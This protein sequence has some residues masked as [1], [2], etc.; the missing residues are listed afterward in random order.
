MM[1]VTFGILYTIGNILSLM[2]T[3]FLVGPRRQCKNM[4][5]RK[6]IVASL[7]F[8]GALIG[9]LA[10]AIST[11]SIMATLLMILIQFCALAWYT[12]SY[13]PYARD[14]VRNA[15]LGCFRRGGG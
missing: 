13:I 14:M 11:G 2:S 15:L 5:H 12:L 1:P 7:V 4:F 6:R 10:V 8:I 9:T 3:G